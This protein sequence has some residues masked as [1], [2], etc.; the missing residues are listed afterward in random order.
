MNK[1]ILDTDNARIEQVGFE[2][3]LYIRMESGQYI[4]QKPYPADP[5]GLAGALTLAMDVVVGKVWL[6]EV[7]AETNNS[8]PKL[9]YDVKKITGAR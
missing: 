9:S 1:L 5:M 4:L 2:Y 8:R 6:Q 7:V 3:R